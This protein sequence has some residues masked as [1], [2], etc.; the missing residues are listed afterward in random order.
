M[1][2]F[3]LIAII[4]TLGIIVAIHEF[5]HFIFAKLN[6]IK[7][8]EFAVGMGPKIAGWKK[9]DTDYC[10]RALPL[11]GYCM[12]E[13]MGEASEDE[14]AYNNKSILARLSV[15]FAGPFF[16]FILAFLLS[17]IIC[18]NANI[19]PPVISEVMESSAA[20]RQWI[21]E[22][23]KNP[24]S[25]K[26]QRRTGRWGCRGT[27]GNCMVCEADHQPIA[28]DQPCGGIAP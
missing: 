11:G 14:N 20:E 12:M 27:N 25:C 2:I 28:R 9:G 16:N 4:I 7:V 6:G 15:C 17:L 19:D 26:R 13:G 5:G 21:R 1:N 10:I 23:E 8:N 18:H 24:G 22:G 3:N